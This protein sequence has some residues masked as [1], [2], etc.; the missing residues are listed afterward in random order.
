MR[1]WARVQTVCLISGFHML[2]WPVWLMQTG[3]EINYLKE[4]QVLRVRETTFL[5]LFWGFMASVKVISI[6]PQ[7]RLGLRKG[8]EC[9]SFLPSYIAHVPIT[10]CELSSKSCP[11]SVDTRM[12]TD[13]SIRKTGALSSAPHSGYTSSAMIALG[14]RNRWSQPRWPS[15]VT[16]MS[17]RD[18]VT[19]N[20]KIMDP[21]SER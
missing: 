3:G 20:Q 21:R 11:A 7:C 10:V 15:V 17:N 16:N 12:E 4:Y 2:L 8:S 9:T 5:L 13:P 1:L 14:R 19:V 6:N 18:S